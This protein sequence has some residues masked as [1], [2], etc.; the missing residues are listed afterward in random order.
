MGLSL[1][2]QGEILFYVFFVS[3][4]FLF[5]S[6]YDGSLSVWIVILSLEFDQGRKSI[7]LI[8]CPLCHCSGCPSSYLFDGLSVIIYIYILFYPGSNICICSKKP[9]SAERMC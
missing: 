3:Q 4:S 1:L 8:A 9:G 2:Q 7:S 6:Q 5:Q